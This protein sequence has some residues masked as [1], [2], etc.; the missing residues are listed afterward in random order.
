MMRATIPLV[1]A[2]DQILKLICATPGR[3]ASTTRANASSASGL[4]QPLVAL[5][6]APAGL[7]G[8]SSKGGQTQATTAE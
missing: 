5:W 4:S 8:Y 2:V 3:P 6:V 7:V 1:E